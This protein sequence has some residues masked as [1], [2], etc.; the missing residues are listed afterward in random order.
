MFCNRACLMTC[1]ARSGSILASY[2]GLGRRKRL[3]RKERRA[4]EKLKRTGTTT[5][6]AAQEADIFAAAFQAHQAG[7]FDA[8][9]QLYGQ[10]LAANPR[11][12]DSLNLLG[13]V[14]LKQGDAK[15]AIDLIG[16]AIALDATA[17][18]YRYNLGMSLEAAGQLEEAAEAFRQAIARQPDYVD[19]LYNLAITL[20][21]LE[22]H[23][24]AVTAYRRVLDIAPT[25]VNALNNLGA[26]L[27]QLE[28]MDEAASCYHAA[29]ALNSQSAEP[30]FNLA[31]LLQEQGVPEKAVSHYETAIKLKPDF[32]D[33]LSN[34]GN[35]LLALGRR[36]ES[37]AAY[38]QA[39]AIK[40]DFAAAYVNLATA[41]RAQQRLQEALAA[42]EAALRLQP[43]L[44]AA[45]VN[46]GMML[47]ALG[48]LNE[49][50]AALEEG[51]RLAP[52][53]Q[54]AAAHTSLILNMHYQGTVSEAE[55]FAAAQRFA[56]HIAVPANTHFK[57][58]PEPGRRL[59]IGYVSGDFNQHPVGFFLSP[60]LANHDPES[61]EIYAYSNNTQNDWMTQQLRAL[62]TQWRNLAGMS[63]RAAALL[64]AADDIDILVDLSGHTGNNRL[65]T[66]A[67]KPAPV[68]L[69][70]LGFWGTTGLPTIDYVLSDATTIPKGDESHY[71]ETVFRLPDSRFCYAPPHQA[72]APATTPPYVKNGYITFGSFNNLSKIGPDV[73]Q[74][75]ARVLQQTPTARLLLKWAS[76]ADGAMR[77]NLFNAFASHGISPEQ[78]ILRAAS[79]HDE[80]LAEYGDMDIALDPFPFSGGLTSCEAL[81]M[82]VPVVTLPGSRS[83][84]RQTQGFLRSIGLPELVAPSADE[85]VRIATDLA[86]DH[87]RLSELRR[88]LRRRMAAS[89]LCD[90][91]VFT[92]NLEAAYRTMWENWCRKAA[93]P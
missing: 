84:S 88:T 6:P 51:I 79:P 45:H 82:S 49:A 52:E 40:P 34:L 76:L 50:A 17:S 24:E 8:A 9:A 33:A 68:Q 42:C 46:L 61:V 26:T 56:A 28:R 47:Q 89:P 85:Y 18:T 90:G 54:V 53:E 69:S 71:S 63:D 30:H 38:T 22:R 39:L 36:D 16:R 19:A 25:H 35:T 87:P 64:I 58:L 70:W 77:Q 74:L 12:A 32:L 7:R 20:G 41:L 83:V 14:T 86:A 44:A 73:I 62:C 93:C 15:A 55:I 66:F 29:I 1:N 13:A 60:V 4:E 75:W 72:P 37:V 23:D 57:N 3:N 48:R 5:A 65:Q 91:Y 2:I 31:K 78:M 67:R 11:H 92:R 27:T 43:D 59:R 81:W 80:M 10:V 21:T